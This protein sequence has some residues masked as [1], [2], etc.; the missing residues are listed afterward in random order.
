MSGGQSWIMK[1]EVFDNCK[2]N[3]DFSTGLERAN[4]KSLKDYKEGKHNEDTDF[5]LKCREFGY[6]IKHNHKMVSYHNDSSYTCLGRIVVRRK[7]EREHTWVKT[8]DKYLPAEVYAQFAAALFNSGLT[9]ESADVLRYALKLNY[10]NYIL[11]QSL[12]AMLNGGF[13]Q[14]LSDDSWNEQGYTKMQEDLQTYRSRSSQFYH[15]H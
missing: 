6:K 12:E 4:M 13:G 2:W 14:I 7:N 9:A 10:Q 15:D 5:S 8:L 1:K 11:T 3:E